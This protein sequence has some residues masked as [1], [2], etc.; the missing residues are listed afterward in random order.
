MNNGPEPTIADVL[1]FM[2]EHVATKEDLK[3]LRTEIQQEMKIGFSKQKA[4]LLDAMDE[5]LADLKGD[6]ITVVRKEDH[7]LVD[8][9]SLLRDKSIISQDEAKI[10]LGKEPFPQ[11]FL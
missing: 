6:I 1:S 3:E 9:I 5:K 10:L 4:E 8:L 2:Q 7:K 11:L